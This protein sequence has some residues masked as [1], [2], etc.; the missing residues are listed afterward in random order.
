MNLYRL[1][2]STVLEAIPKLKALGIKTRRP[3]DYYA[4]M[5]KS[6]D[7]MHKVG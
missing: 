4:E 6:D 2:Q 1:G 5:S 3:D 7:H